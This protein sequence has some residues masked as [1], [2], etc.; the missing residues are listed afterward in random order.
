MLPPVVEDGLLLGHLPLLVLHIVPVEDGEGDGEGG[1][2]GQEG[3]KDRTN[4][5]GNEAKI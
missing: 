5:G 4:V 3:H 1:G 2:D